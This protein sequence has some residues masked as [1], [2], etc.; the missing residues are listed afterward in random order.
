MQDERQREIA[1]GLEEVKFKII[2]I[3]I[4]IRLVW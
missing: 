1:P 2:V 4:V 3:E